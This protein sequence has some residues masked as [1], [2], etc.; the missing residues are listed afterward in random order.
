MNATG[1]ERLP[2]ASM[3]LAQRA[4]KALK[5]E[6]LLELSRRPQPIG[7]LEIGTGSGGIAHYFATH[8]TLRCE[9]Q[10]VDV[11]DNRIQRDGYGFQLVRDTRLPFAD[12]AFDIVI[13]NHVIE[14]VGDSAAQLRHLAEIHRVLKP[15]GAGYLAVPNRWMVTEPHYH[16]KFLS[17][18]PH[19]WR[20][21][22]LRLRRRGVFYDVEPLQR[23]ELER[24]LA[25]S[26][27]AFRNLCIDAWRELLD[28]E[29]PSALRTRMLR[30]VPDALLRP[31]R[32]IIP[33]LIYRLT[34]A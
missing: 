1:C 22:Y 2:H 32:G 15:G 9:V 17:W 13:S 3:D 34:L 31:L 6:H 12:A 20:S 19:A 27:F 4:R 25:A 18:L 14:H 21:P 10:A 26:G 23:R 24:M 16:L 33:T 29:R 7:L 8:P 5:I 11:C 28:I 30:T